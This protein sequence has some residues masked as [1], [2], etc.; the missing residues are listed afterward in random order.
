MSFGGNIAR[1]PNW[2]EACRS[3]LGNRAMFK[4]NEAVGCGTSPDKLGIE[5]LDPPR[6]RGEKK[7]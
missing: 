1:M 7:G 5:R 4:L 2:L 6:C 3:A